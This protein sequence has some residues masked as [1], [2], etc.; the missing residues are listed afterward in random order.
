MRNG[1]QDFEC[2][3]L[4]EQKVSQIRATLA[5]RVAAL[6]DPRQRGVEIAFRVIPDYYAHTG[7]PELLYQARRQAIEETLA[8]DQSP[9]VLL[10]TTPPEHSPVAKGCAVDLHGWAEPGTVLTANGESVPVAADGLF[11]AQLSPSG[12]GKIV[13]EVRSQN[14]KRSIVRQ[15]REAEAAS[16]PAVD[17]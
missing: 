1:L 6:I 14:G 9:R 8:L 3:W 4:L 7:N 10:Q 17:R 2:L 11:L 5:P 16:V 12:E 15:F 13:L